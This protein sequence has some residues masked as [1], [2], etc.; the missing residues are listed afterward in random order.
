MNQRIKYVFFGK[1]VELKEIGEFP[2]QPASE[3]V[4]DSKIIFNKYCAS[5]VETKLEQRNKVNIKHSSNSHYFYVS[6]QKIFF[7]ALVDSSYPENHIFKLF[8][9]IQ[10]E[11]IH[12]LRDDKGKLN[13]IGMSKLRDLVSQYQTIEETNPIGQINKE[14]TDIKGEMRKNITKIV[15]NVEDAENLKAQSD[16]IKTK[17][18]QF[19]EQSNELKKRAWWQNTK[20]III[21]AVMFAILVIVIVVA[22]VFSKKN[23]NNNGNNDNKNVIVNVNSSLDTNSGK[24]VPPKR[25]L[26]YIEYE[27]IK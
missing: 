26:N 27:K 2:S 7:L 23:S 10:K 6:D 19:Y 15:S 24:E 25:F 18:N 1:A 8:E 11:N 17:S 9:S 13:T 14:L 5:N 21:L 3:W 16:E 4:K 20:M 12:L 22:A